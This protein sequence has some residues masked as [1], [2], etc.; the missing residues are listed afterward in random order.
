[1]KQ[2]DESEYLGW[3]AWGGAKDGS[4]ADSAHSAKMVTTRTA[5]ECL[6]GDPHP[7]SVGSRARREKAIVDGE[8]CSWYAC[9]PCIERELAEYE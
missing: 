2:R 9:L 7:I 5:H 4:G 6:V 8:W 1:M 3:D